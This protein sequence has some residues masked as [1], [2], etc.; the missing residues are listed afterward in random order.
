MSPD[1]YFR[2]HHDKAAPLAASR[3]GTAAAGTATLPTRETMPVVVFVTMKERVF[4]TA[5]LGA[6]CVAST[7]A[8][9]LLA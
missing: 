4:F 6:R 1:A 2:R 7:T 8:D 3:A 5:R 9:E